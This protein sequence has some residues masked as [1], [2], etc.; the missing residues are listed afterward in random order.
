MPHA[1]LSRRRGKNRG[2][3]QAVVGGM[4]KLSLFA[5]A[6]IL[7]TSIADAG[8]IYIGMPLASGNVSRFAD[9][10]EIGQA[11]LSLQQLRAVADWLTNHQAGWSG[12]ITEASLEP[13]SMAVTL[14][15]DDGAITSISVIS[16]ANGGS[17]L[18]LTG[19]GTW[20]YSS[21]WGIYKSW[22]ATR[23]LSEQELLSFR[24][25]LGA[26]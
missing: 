5:I 10:Q 6:V 13:C 12:M 18:R 22:A 16:Q 17:Y 25:L 7:S 26:G 3:Q 11:D 21:L 9:R 4:N 8:D 2:H 24:K 14:K 15:H 20:A 1:V 23:P 19:P